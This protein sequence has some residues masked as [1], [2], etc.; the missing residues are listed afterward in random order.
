MGLNPTR[1][2]SGRQW[3]LIPEFLSPSERRWIRG[4]ITAAV[5]SFV[6]L[7]IGIGMQFMARVPQAGGT[8]TIG[9]VGSPQF[10]NPILAR[11]GTIDADL[12][13][14]MFRGLV[15]ID[16]NLLPVPD[17]AESITLSEDRTQYTVT[18]RPNLYWSDDEPLTADDVKFTIDTIKDA[19]FASPHRALFTSATVEVT[20]DRTVVFT[21]EKPLAAFGTYLELGILPRHVW[22]DATPQTMALAELNVKPINNG[23]YKFLSVTKDRSGAVRQMTFVRNKSAAIQP[24]L[25][26]LNIKFYAERTAAID[27]LRTDAIDIFGGLTPDEVS[28]LPKK[29][30]RTTTP[31]SQLTAVFINQ[32]DNPVLRA[33]EVR[34]ALA[35]TVDRQGLIEASLP[36]LADV[37]QGPVLPGYPGFLSDL[38]IPPLDPVAA[39]AALEEAGWKRNDAGIRQKGATQFVFAVTAPDDPVYRVVAESLAEG[40]R[41]LGAGV[42]VKLIDP[43]RIQRDTIKPRDYEILLFGQIH[44]T[45]GDLYPFWHSSQQRDPGYNLSLFF[46]KQLDTDLEDA[47]TTDSLDKRIADYQSFQRIVAD[48]IP[49]IFLYQHR[50]VQGHRS[51]VKIPQAKQLVSP[52]DRFLLTANWYTRTK[53]SWR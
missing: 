23:P 52:S 32:R 29:I 38:T 46:N 45:D 7:L 10:I 24:Y 48:E 11:D 14:L 42:E 25:Q 1:I 26:K 51:S 8:V 19:E 6:T 4:F 34:R 36:G 18:L 33:K 22:S 12:T 3:R 17:L 9:L 13:K 21:L 31:I 44:D 49:A 2:P 15:R 50:Y 30:V 28:A 41:T 47:R 53:I 20:D 37:L 5:I 27:A 35:M 39:N 40:W 16:E 43:S